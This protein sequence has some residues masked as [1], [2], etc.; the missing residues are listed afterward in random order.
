MQRPK[1]QILAL[2]ALSFVVLAPLAPAG[3][4]MPDPPKPAA[5]VLGKFAFMVCRV[6]GMDA[7]ISDQ[8]IRIPAGTEFTENHPSIEDPVSMRAST[9]LPFMVVTTTAPATLP[10]DGFCVSVPVKSHGHVDDSVIR[11]SLGEMFEPDA[12]WQGPSASEP[13]TLTYGYW[14]LA[15]D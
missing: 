8:T 9:R 12:N 7:A 15:S 3:H 4:A 11:R 1:L 6:P 5:P 14:E 2:L 13:V 10:A